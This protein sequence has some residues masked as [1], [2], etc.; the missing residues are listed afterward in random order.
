MSPEQETGSGEIDARSDVFALGAVLYE[1]LVGEPPPPRSPSGLVR[2][3]DNSTAIRFDSGT[4]KSAALV[5]P[6][7]RTI[8]EKAMAMHPADRYQDA[9]SFAQ[10][11]RGV[12]EEIAKAEGST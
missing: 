1:C 6:L 3:G 8:I 4:Q 9:R 2:T 7:W 10:A 11:L 12:R 5:P